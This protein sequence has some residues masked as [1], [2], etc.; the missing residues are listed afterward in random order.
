MSAA[1]DAA[2]GL[3]GAALRIAIV[4]PTHPIKG[5]VAVHTTE[6]AHHLQAAGHDVTL[7]SWSQLY[8]AM[9]YPGETTVPLDQPEVTPFP[10]TVRVLHWARPGSWRRAGREL[11][12]YDLVIVVHVI[13][14]IVPAH[15]TLMRAAR[16]GP[17][18]P[19]ILGLA[20]NVLPHEPRPGDEALIGAFLSRLD[21]VLVHT[22]AQAEVAESL[23]ADP[24]RTVPLPP[25]LPGGPR[26][27]REPYAGPPRLIALGIVRPYKGLDV[28]LEALARVPGPTLTIAGEVW[29]DLGSRLAA[30]AA[31]PDLA[32]RVT[33]REGYVPAADIAPLLAE[34]DVMALTYLSATASQNALLAQAHGLVVVASTVGSFPQDV[35]DG[36]DGLLV[37]PGDVDGLADALRYL[38]EPGN[39]GESGNLGASDNL[40]RLRAAVPQVNLSGPWARYLGTIEALAAD[41]SATPVTVGSS[42][43]GTGTGSE[44]GSAS[45][46]GTHGLGRLVGRLGDGLRAARPRIELARGD[47]P[48]WVTP[49]DVLATDDDATAVR[50]LARSL[51]L[52]R[53]GS[54]VEQWAA[55]GALAAVLR[56]RDDGRRSSLILDR[57]GGASPFT[58]WAKAIGFAPVETEP[59]GELD[60]EPESLDVLARLHPA[61]V[62]PEQAIDLFAQA[63]WALRPGGLLVTTFAL[64]PKTVPGTLAAA[65]LRALLAQADNAGL[66]LIGDLDGDFTA[67]VRRAEA[68]ARDPRAAYGLA[69]LTWRRR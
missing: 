18:S 53:R 24:V 23:G 61:D 32:G 30:R 48:D 47:L 13:P 45:G 54:R 44:S 8:P 36:V 42:G 11:A 62:E 14:Q 20:H 59:V 40:A 34:H 65:D 6:L 50:D 35:H 51:G 39:L 4:G 37:E 43:T 9:L 17:K 67:T 49:T 26:A 68:A 10:R 27:H 3:A 33:F 5:G 31:Q 2:Q 19:R 21:G 25:H 38:G 22:A 57:S 15:L 28:L 52:P 12:A 55:L 56:V 16:S 7:V 1:A 29:G 64:G 60:V 58:T 41:E 66:R 63:A 46:S 69:R